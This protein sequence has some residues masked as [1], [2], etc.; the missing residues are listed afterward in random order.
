MPARR[1]KRVLVIEIDICQ[2]CGDSLGTSR[3]SSSPRSLRR[4]WR[5]PSARRRN[6]ISSSYRLGARVAPVLRAGR[7][8]AGPQVG[9]LPSRHNAPYAIKSTSLRQEGIECAFRETHSGT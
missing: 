2:R 4:S 3:A 5:T 6:R 1:L 9:R 7:G 8:S